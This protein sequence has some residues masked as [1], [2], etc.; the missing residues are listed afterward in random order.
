MK[1]RVR[2]QKEF[3]KFLQDVAKQVNLD[4]ITV[5]KKL[6]LDIYR[7]V[8]AGTPVDTGRAMNNWNLSIATP[9]RSVTEQGGVVNAVQT[10][11]QTGALGELASL[12]PF[13]TVWISNNLPYIMELEEGH[14]RQAPNGWVERAV[15][16]N[17][18][19]L[20]I[21]Q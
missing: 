21:L 2:N 12:K 3:A 17:L 11:K 9:D 8:I 4:V 6:A 19:T 1:L 14:S 20:A 13:Q 5:Q 16:T 15:Q 10:I 7:D 18:N